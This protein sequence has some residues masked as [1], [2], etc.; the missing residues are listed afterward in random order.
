MSTVC[1]TSVI[2][3]QKVGHE[4]RSDGYDV[5][6][7]AGDIVICLGVDRSGNDVMLHSSTS[8]MVLSPGRSWLQ[9]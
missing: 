4:T 6:L 5:E 8:T 9:P 1:N 2:Y 7:K 3:V